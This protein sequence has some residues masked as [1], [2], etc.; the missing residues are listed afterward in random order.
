LLAAVAS[1]Q[2]REL[3]ATT[4]A[5]RAAI[6]RFVAGE[7][8]ADAVTSARKLRDEGLLVTLDYLG[9]E[10]AD[11]VRAAATLTQYTQLLGELAA[12]GLT[13]D[14]GVEVSVKPTAVG[15]LLDQGLAA[16]H[17]ARIAD[18]AVGCGTTITLDAEDHRTADATLRLAAGLREQVP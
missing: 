2:I 16:G 6:G 5:A 4:P 14:G 9:D 12:A 18:A 11:R 15:L 3:A 7:T 13:R 1:D 8:I 10:A 17:M